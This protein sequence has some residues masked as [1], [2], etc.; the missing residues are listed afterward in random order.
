MN[1]SL[2]KAV[3]RSPNQ[4]RPHSSETKRTHAALPEAVPVTMQEAVGYPAIA[5]ETQTMVEHAVVL[6]H[7]QHFLIMNTHGDI[8]PPGHCSLG[9]FQDDTRVLS[10]YQLRVCGGTPSL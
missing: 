1:A 8:S 10:H 3:R 6:K 5:C 9:L 7:G 2:R 4:G